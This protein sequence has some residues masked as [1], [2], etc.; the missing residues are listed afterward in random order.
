ML[1]PIDFSIS[2]LAELLPPPVAHRVNKRGEKCDFKR[3]A[4][5]ARYGEPASH[6]F[7]V[8]SGLVRIGLN[9]ADGS[10]F[11]LSIMG[12][13]SS[14]GE[15]ALFLDLP[16]QFDAHCETDVSLIRL[17][18]KQVMQLINEEPAFALASITVA[19]A[20]SHT[21]LNYIADVFNLPLD[22]RTAELLSQMAAESSD[23]QTVHC[24]QVDL[25]HA[26]AISRVSMSKA[27]KSLE[28][29]QLIKRA[30]GKILVPSKPNLDSWISRKKQSRL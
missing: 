25:A 11:N 29:K 14:F 6:L 21:M 2:K 28:A 7:I 13:G 15:T 22:V 4:Q 20:R 19:H 23:G 18:K 8:Q 30:Y 3:G 9:E 27:L 10:R 12:S 1:N 16:V 5:I 26:V 17:S 24:R